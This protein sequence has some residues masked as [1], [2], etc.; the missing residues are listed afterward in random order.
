MTK[1]E[2]ITETRALCREAATM[3]RQRLGYDQV[4]AYRF[5]GDDSGEVVAETKRDD[6]EP[7][8]GL[9]YPATDIPKQARELFRRNKVRVLAHVNATPPLIE[10][11]LPFA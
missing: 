10:P 9:R 3:V 4:M 7:Y 8:L 1:L 6:L 11:S 5:H 2:P